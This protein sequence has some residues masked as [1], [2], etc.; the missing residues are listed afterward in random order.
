MNVTNSAWKKASELEKIYCQTE[1]E[2]SNSENSI[3]V[4]LVSS[5]MAKSAS[6]S[7]VD[8]KLT[9]GMSYTIF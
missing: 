8:Q 2:F 7:D 4:T 5:R 9:W 6:A 3:C 1:P